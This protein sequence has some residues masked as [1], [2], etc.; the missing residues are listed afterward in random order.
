MIDHAFALERINL[1]PK[2][3]ATGI[4]P[5]SIETER[6]ASAYLSDVMNRLRATR[7]RV[8]KV[9]GPTQ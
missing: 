8:R 6:Q 9:G 3:K 1:A 4:D 2:N 7:A 5:H